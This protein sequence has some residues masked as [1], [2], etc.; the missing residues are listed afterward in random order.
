MTTTKK[1]TIAAEP[2]TESTRR[3]RIVG[4]AELGVETAAKSQ[5][6]WNDL[7]FAYAD[8]AL[9]AARNNLSWFESLY[10]QNR[11]AM[12]TMAEARNERARAILDRLS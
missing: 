10:E 11:K 1:S 9:Q 4:W 2:R 5:K 3:E 8:L 6:Q 7:T 12:A